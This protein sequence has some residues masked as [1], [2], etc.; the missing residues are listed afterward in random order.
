MPTADEFVS[1]T[2]KK[3]LGFVDFDSYLLR[4]LRKAIRE[5]TKRLFIQGSFEERM[6]ISGS[7]ANEILVE[8]KPILQDGFAHD[9]SGRL[10]DLQ[11]EDDRYAT[12]ENVNGQIYEVGASYVEYPREIRIN[13]RT[14][15]P[16]YDRFVEGIGVQATADS[17][18]IGGSTITLVVDSL[19]EA[20][21][22]GDHTGRDVRVFL[23]L[24][25][26]DIGNTATAAIETCFVF[27]D[28]ENKITTAGYLGQTVPEPDE[29]AYVVQL[30]GPIVY[31]DTASNKPTARPSEVFFIGTVEGNGG[32][33]DTFDISGQ[34]V[35]QAQSADL[36]TVDPLPDWYDG[37]GN[38][39]GTVQA[40]LDKIIYDLATVVTGDLTIAGSQKISSAELPFWYDSTTNPISSVYGQL[41]KIVYDLRFLD[42]ENSISGAKKIS[43]Y[44]PGNWAD[45]EGAAFGS[46]Q[47]VLNDFVAA[48]TSVTGQRGAGKLTAPARAA[49]ADSTA[50]PAAN[51]DAA[52]NK[53]VTDLATGDGTA[54]I[55][56]PAL[57]GDP[58]D[59]ISSGPL[60]T[61]LGIIYGQLNLSERR[62]RANFEAI[63]VQSLRRAY[64]NPS[65]TVIDI[66]CSINVLGS[67]AQLVAV[68]DNDTLLVRFSGSQWQAA[69]PDD[70]YSAGIRAVVN[71]TLGWVWV[72]YGGWIQRSSDGF[73][74]TTA[75][76]L[77]N[78][79]TDIA[80]KPTAT[81]T[82][83]AVGLGGYIWTSTN[84]TTWNQQTGAAGMHTDDYVSVRW[85]AGVFVVTTST[86][87]IMT[88][89]S[90]S[91]GTWTQ[92]ATGTLTGTLP[93]YLERQLRY[94]ALF[95]FVALYNRNSGEIGLAASLDGITWSV[96]TSGNDSNLDEPNVR[97]ALLERSA[98]YLMTKD[99]TQPYSLNAMVAH[100]TTVRPGTANTSRQIFDIEECFPFGAKDLNGVL[101]V[102]GRLN[103]GDGCILSGAPYRAPDNVF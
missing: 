103:N 28:G 10:L 82:Y 80:F 40:A 67:T 3:L 36:I 17:A 84:T 31:R 71:G 72:G 15:K 69:T 1:L 19:F 20:G 85:G 87:K 63:A 9:G 70:G 24:G 32:T 78:N 37:A 26:G 44:S 33:P 66:D 102:V 16:E 45:T 89:P 11:D 4:Y 56:S 98:V 99:D 96:T 79:F 12:F 23:L 83:C 55:M 38:P 52:V 77:G 58:Y 27:Y 46:I 49:W 93:A 65:W 64:T 21:G 95:G 34:Q 6:P 88:S 90:G 25:P 57:S 60:A 81:A 14:G 42:G 73:G 18:V 8:L 7:D 61:V 47:D 91:T 39:G 59:V 53:I 75:K 50:N 30:I 76:F 41:Y 29:D 35:I 86:G 43:A 2:S 22:A 48:L 13:P 101:F 92:R 5:A 97:L 100:H 74:W 62:A 68:G 54:K 94:N 51:L